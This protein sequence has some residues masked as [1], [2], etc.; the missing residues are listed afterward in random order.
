MRYLLQ[1]V[2]SRELDFRREYIFD[3][4]KIWCHQ[5]ND[6]TSF[7]ELESMPSTYL[8]IL[9]IVGHN[10]AVENYLSSYVIPEKVIVAITCDKSIDLKKINL[11]DKV[12]YISNQK[13]HYSDFLKGNLFGFKFDLTES[14][15]VFYNT[16]KNQDIK[17]RLNASFTRI[18]G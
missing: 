1:N 7:I 5:K 2:F 17:H 16:D 11:P 15:L 12:V 14:E 6:G 4:L 18:K 9:F 10:H 8:D 13:N 3:T